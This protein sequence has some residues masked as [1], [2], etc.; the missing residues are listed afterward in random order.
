MAGG[1]D[2]F[3]GLIAADGAG[4][5]DGTVFGAGGLHGDGFGYVTLGFGHFHSLLAAD[6][7]GGGNGAALGAGGFHG[8]GF[9]YVALGFDHFHHGAAADGAGFGDG[10]V[11]GAGSVHGHG[12]IYML[13]GDDHGK[14]S[15]DLVFAGDGADVGACG[16]A[17][18]G[19]APG[20]HVGGNGQGAVD[21]RAVGAGFHHQLGQN[22]IQGC[23]VG[24]GV[25]LD[26]FAAQ[27]DVVS[28]QAGGTGE[29]EQTDGVAGGF[30]LEVVVAVAPAQVILGAAAPP[31]AGTGLVDLVDTVAGV[32]DG[33]GVGGRAGSQAGAAAVQ[34]G[35]IVGNG[36]VAAGGSKGPA[37]IGGIHGDGV[38]VDGDVYGVVAAGG[39][40]QSLGIALGHNQILGA[41]IDAVGIQ[42]VDAAG[43]QSDPLVIS[44]GQLRLGGLGGNLGFGGF[45]GSF[46]NCGCVGT[47]NGRV[48]GADGAGVNA[49]CVHGDILDA[50]GIDVHQQGDFH[51]AG[52]GTVGT[53]GLGFHVTGTGMDE[54]QRDLTGGAVVFHI[55]GIAN[56]VEVVGQLVISVVVAVEQGDIHVL[57]GG[58]DD[59]APLVGMA[60]VTAVVQQR[61]VGHH[62][63]GLG[64]IQGGHG[65][66][67][68]GQLGRSEG[69]GD[70][71]TGVG[72]HIGHADEV[73]VVV[74]VIGIAVN[75]VGTGAVH[76]TGDVC[77][78]AVTVMVGP[79]IVYMYSFV[80]QAGANG[81]GNTAQRADV[82]GLVAGEDVANAEDSADFAGGN[83]GNAAEGVLHQGGLA[84]G[85]AGVQVA[86]EGDGIDRGCGSCAC[87]D[88]YQGENHHEHKQRGKDSLDLICH[89]HVDTLLFVYLCSGELTVLTVRPKK[90][91]EKA[92][93]KGEKCYHC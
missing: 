64:V 47:G 35:A 54:V 76:Q 25:I 48:H 15:Q 42:L 17:V 77:N 72:G 23:A 33:P 24:D 86:E 21:I 85:R 22:G 43:G 40:A 36:V 67:E 32:A 18:E 78:T 87:V 88:R 75:A 46:G 39:C 92:E 89:F 71:V 62:E 5:D 37:V 65:I 1:S 66:G 56:T 8:D 38:A 26:G 57:S 29:L 70:A 2:H 81:G 91:A 50:V 16:S 80:I 59:L 58:I 53:G 45:G 69:G 52:G 93:G 63:Q 19:L 55:H 90:T 27:T 20:D 12:F 79:D 84:V 49:V 11:F 13:C 28:T 9:G 41:G 51:T 83:I 60:V 34:I 61:H 10:A 4:G 3:H 6:S 31:A 44:I 30:G 68:V 14:A 7:A 74:A 73:D 82:L